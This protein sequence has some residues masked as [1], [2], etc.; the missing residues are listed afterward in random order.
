MLQSLSLSEMTQNGQLI[1]R[2]PCKIMHFVSLENNKMFLLVTDHTANDT[3]ILD[4]CQRTYPY[5]QANAPRKIVF[6]MRLT[7]ENDDAEKAEIE[8]TVRLFQDMFGEDEVSYE[9]MELEPKT[10]PTEETAS[11]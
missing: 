9:L 11:E 4:M 5:C 7:D 1:M 2:P 8:E 3:V 10:L 6:S